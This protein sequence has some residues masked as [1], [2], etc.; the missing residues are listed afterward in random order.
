VN[1]LNL[2]ERHFLIHPIVHLCGARGPTKAVL[3][4][5]VAIH[6]LRND[7][8]VSVIAPTGLTAIT[9]NDPLPSSIQEVE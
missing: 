7:P 2:V 4:L 6:L 3:Y 9:K 8:V 1:L 5:A